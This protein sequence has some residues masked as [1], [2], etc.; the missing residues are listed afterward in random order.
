MTGKNP[1]VVAGLLVTS[2]RL[3]NKG[4]NS[5]AHGAGYVF[6]VLRNGVPLLA[7]TKDGIELKH[8][9]NVVHEVSISY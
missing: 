8:F 6:R 9:K 4:G 3:R 7:E 1:A 5:I 2:G